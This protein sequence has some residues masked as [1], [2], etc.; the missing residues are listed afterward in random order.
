M[1]EQLDKLDQHI[2]LAINNLSCHAIDPIWETLSQKE[3]WFPLYLAVL[4]V[5]FYRLGWKKAIPVTLS[6]ILTIVACDQF[7]NLIKDSVGRLRPL[8]N[9][10]MIENGLRALEGR[11]NFY[12]FFSAHAANSFGFAICSSLGLKNDTKHS[13][14]AYTIGIM[15][16]ATLIGLSRIFCGKHYFGDV[17]VGTMIG[18]LF[19]WLL[20]LCAREAINRLKL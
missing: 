15:I 14:K 16:W 1:L 19:G 10:W 8:Y 3:I 2:T 9:S 20:A 5:L 6:I 7:A 4:I 18:L 12:G 11:G 17:L 13:Y